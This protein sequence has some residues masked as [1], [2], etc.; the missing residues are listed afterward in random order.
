MTVAARKSSLLCVTLLTLGFAATARAQTVVDFNGQPRVTLGPVGL[1]PAVSLS[2]VGIDNNVFNAADDPKQDFTATLVP[3]LDTWVR[4]GRLAARLR[5]TLNVV[6]FRQFADQRGLNT[7]QDL[8]VALRV[9]RVTPFVNAKY[10]N[11]R[12]RPSIDVD[13]RVR[14]SNSN[15]GAG[16]QAALGSRISWRLEGQRQRT[17]F[18]EDAVYL[19]T[20]LNQQLNETAV[21]INSSVSY[22]VTPL[23]SLVFSAQQQRDRFDLSPLRNAD[24]LR[25]SPSVEF[26]PTALIRGRA[27]VGVRAFNAKDPR[28]PD[29]TGLVAS[30]DLGYTYRG[31]TQ[32]T[33]RADRDVAYSFSPDAP[34]SVQT[35]LSGLVTHRLGPTW[36]VT[37][38]AGRQHLDYRALDGATPR[39][40]GDPL[41]ALSGTGSAFVYGAGAGLR[42]GHGSRMG[43]NVD[44]SKRPA[45]L[46]G[47]YENLR[48]YTTVSY[49]F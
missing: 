26:A 33:F 11:T 30:I 46:S 34:Y 14:R 28:V 19:G 23:T 42:F 3:S 1:T 39:V 36:D 24:T 21:S 4:A 31:S 48:Y 15:F 43:F 18:A 41:A 35:S 6:Y 25:L 8:T 44:Y 32:L 37:A 13:T 9:H 2:N 29:F 40:D 10:L 45:G 16:L 27:A 7:A 49:A 17:D 20:S 12:E 38:S 5:S 22:A 47:R